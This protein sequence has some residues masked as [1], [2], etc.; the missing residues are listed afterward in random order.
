MASMKRPLIAVPVTEKSKDGIISAF[1]R[2]S[3]KG[4]DLIEWRADCFSDIEAFDK[5]EEVLSSS[6]E[7][8]LFTVR[9]KDEGGFFS[10][11]RED[12]FQ[13]LKLSAATKKPKIIDVQLRDLSADKASDKASFVRELKESGTKVLISYHD[14]S[15]TPS[16]EEMEEI[17]YSMKD[18]GASIVK[19]AVTAKDPE[20][21]VRLL[22][23][24]ENFTRKNPNIDT[25]TIS[26]GPF[27]ILSRIGGFITGSCIT[28]AS[29]DKEKASAPG[30]LTFD[31]M[32]DVLSIIERNQQ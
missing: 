23:L 16:Y 32:K 18:S 29:E 19:L 1:K 6:P 24:S 4:A 13:L 8:L 31:D 28:F 12:Y 20:E 11:S 5:V 17:L 15:G 3:E 7:N 30:Q 14:F 26:M 10:G 9:T 27:G 2:L 22:K 25:V 21:A